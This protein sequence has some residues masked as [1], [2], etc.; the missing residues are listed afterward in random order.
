MSDGTDNDEL[1]IKVRRLEL[2]NKRMQQI[3]RETAIEMCM[4]CECPKSDNILI[5][6]NCTM[7]RY[8]LLKEGVIPP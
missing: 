7:C 2:N 1:W 4:L 6:E 5:R 8:R 3:I